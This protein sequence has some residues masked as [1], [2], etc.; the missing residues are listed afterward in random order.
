MNNSVPEN[1]Q[2]I[3]RGRIARFHEFSKGKAADVTVAVDKG[4][5]ANGKQVWLIQTIC[6]IPNVYRHLKEGMMVEIH[7]HIYPHSY[8]KDGNRI[9]TRDII[10]DYILFLKSENEDENEV[11]ENNEIE[12][13]SNEA[14]S[15]EENET[16]SAEAFF[17]I[18]N[19]SG[20]NLFSGKETLC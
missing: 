18:D 16:D 1:N 15:V 3:L 20:V 7:G 4:R 19:L 10:A 2:L 13:E 5:A 17:T 11:Y 14:D 6:F 9:Y 12:S 8:I